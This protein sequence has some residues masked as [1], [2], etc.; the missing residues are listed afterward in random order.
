L[1]GQIAATPYSHYTLFPA[2]HTDTSNLLRDLKKV[3]LLML[4]ALPVAHAGE[5][6]VDGADR[7]VAIADI[8]GAFDAMVETL[9]QADVI[10]DSLAW[11]G[12]G[13]HLVIVGD[14]LD[15]GPKSRHAMDLL[16]RLEGEAAATGGNVQVV[17]G[18][19]ESMNMIGDLRYVSKA[20]Y[21]AFAADETAEERER[22][23]AAYSER[24][25]RAASREKFEEQFPNGFF[26]LRRAF[27]S[28]GEYGRWLLTKPVIV[29]V[30]GTA[31]VHGGLSPL[32]EELGLDGIN[33]GLKSE[34]VEYV[35]AL[36]ILM[37]AEVL[38]P[39]DG[40]YDTQAIL[41]S[42]LP[43]LNETPA[44]LEAIRIAK[45]LGQSDLFDPDGP[46]WY[47]GNVACGGLIEE[48]RLEAALAVL[49]A[50]RVVVGHTP[51]PNR[52]VLQRFD[53]RII[54]IDT[55]MLNFY[56][57]GSGNAL[58]LD[59]NTVSV[60][61]QSGDGPVSPI[62]HP[63]SVGARPGSMSA[64]ELQQLLEEGEIL[65]KEKGP[66]GRTIVTVGDGRRSVSA[67]FSKRVGRGFYP[68]VAAYRLDRLL[69]LDMVPVTAIRKV[70]G[71]EGS[72]QFLTDRYSDESQRAASG[73][74]G[75]ASCSLGDQ[76]AAMYVFD[77]LI[78]NEGRSLQRMLYDTGT[79]RLMLS[80]HDR[81]FAAKKG[82]PRH[83]KAAPLD[84]SD[85][86]KRALMELTDAVLQENFSDVLDK[87]R[88]KA[89]ISRRDELLAAPG[90][91]Q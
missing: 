90:E 14:I 20:E 81:A 30:N 18:N 57:K 32:V 62:A 69:Q 84:V 47:R 13:T 67:I 56:Y 7:V 37:D 71:T 88:L 53:G 10:D 80:E 34:L 19:H 5:W 12:G 59:G 41:D 33:G 60:V 64:E 6:R 11:S 89:L 58:V 66:S 3:L 31:F 40:H 25:G 36:Q 22:W 79:W 23:F 76:W 35:S 68:G 54:E 82:R 27:S 21:A 49:G 86:W 43:G 45:R 65:S 87:R 91:R 77:V 28:D 52:R 9:Q 74:G 16:M 55:G 1:P 39:T 83:L 50:E 73:R 24:N 42:Y 26:A 44:V 75:G 46:L 17:I 70:R 85:G 2:I 15:R 61:N 29:V 48:Y 38:L 63:R 51:T 72:L 78:Y 8:H 4:I